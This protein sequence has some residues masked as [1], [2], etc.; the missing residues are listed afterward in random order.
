MKSIIQSASYVLLLLIATSCVNYEISTNY[1]AKKYTYE[2]YDLR[3]FKDY[4][5]VNDIYKQWLLDKADTTRRITSGI[6]FNSKIVINEVNY[7]LKISE[8]LSK[9]DKWNKESLIV[10]D[11]V[12]KEMYFWNMP[13]GRYFYPLAETENYFFFAPEFDGHSE[14]R[15]W[16]IRDW[17]HGLILFHKRNLD[18]YRIYY[19]VNRIPVLI[20]EKD[21]KIR[22]VLSEL[23]LSWSLLGWLSTKISDHFH[24]WSYIKTG[25]YIEIVIDENFNVVSEGY[26]KKSEINHR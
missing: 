12:N 3:D 7:V 19:F 4:K 6:F 2:L 5:N 25:K 21:N 15:E 10:V 9:V 14:M 20:E 26:I 11:T 22:V 17:V 16:N 1:N 13:M 23:R 18:E 24:D 8:T